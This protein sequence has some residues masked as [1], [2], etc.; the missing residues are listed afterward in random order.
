MQAIL[1]QLK[2]TI[3]SAT[4]LITNQKNTIVDLKTQLASVSSEYASFV[5]AE[6]VEDAEAEAFLAQ[7]EQIST[8]LST[9]ISASESSESVEP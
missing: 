8:A 2:A 3:A 9:V 7:L 6:D 5:E 4:T 1:E